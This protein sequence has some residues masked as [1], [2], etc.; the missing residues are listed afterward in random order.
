MLL[1]FREGKESVRLG[2]TLQSTYLLKINR[3]QSAQIPTGAKRRPGN[4]CSSTPTTPPPDTPATR[5]CR[6]ILEE[7]FF[8]NGHDIRGHNPPR[9]SEEVD[10]EPVLIQ[11]PPAGINDLVGQPRP[12]INGQVE[13]S[14]LS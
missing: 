11:R 13:V 10:S 7:E 9:E 8:I 2:K 14:E 6:Q 4:S 3:K 12:E 5:T 1:N